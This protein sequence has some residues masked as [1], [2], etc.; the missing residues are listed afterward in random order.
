MTEDFFSLV[1]IAG[2][3]VLFFIVAGLTLRWMA[4]ILDARAT[5]R[6]RMAKSAPEDGSG[7]LAKDNSQ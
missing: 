3:L 1:L 7:L 6:R 4:D 5:K 2:Y